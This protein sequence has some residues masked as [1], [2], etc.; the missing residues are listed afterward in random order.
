MTRL[1]FSPSL[2]VFA[3]LPYREAG[4]SFHKKAG[5]WD[6]DYDSPAGIPYGTVGRNCMALL[7]T[8]IVYTK[9]NVMEF[10]FFSDFLKAA[11]TKATGGKTGTISSYQEQLRSVFY[12]TVTAKK[13]L[14]EE[15]RKRELHARFMIGEAL[16]IDSVEVA[17]GMDD[18]GI[19]FETRAVET[20]KGVNSSKF[21]L[22]VTSGFKDYV[23]G[24]A[25][26]FDM[27]TYLDLTSP[28]EKDLYVWLVRRLHGLSKSTVITWE[29]LYEQFSDSYVPK[30]APEYDAKKGKHLRSYMRD[31][32]SKSLAKIKGSAYVESRITRFRNEGFLL[33]P[34]PQHV[35]R[36][37]VSDST[38][39]A[40]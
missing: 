9:S 33:K 18:P 11:G 34:S 39:Y 32:I 26:P 28:R 12:L 7:T 31:E 14:R 1:G 23:L 22:K 8:H 3:P 40:V 21:G 15:K 36:K 6:V 24:H 17:N 38:G 30:D 16:Y 2:Q 5:D 20:W 29:N 35:T 37:E 27:N 10:E 19:L 4:C 25:V 13:I